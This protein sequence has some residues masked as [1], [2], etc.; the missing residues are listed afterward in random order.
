MNS[1][2]ISARH[3]LVDNEYEAKDILKLLK[4]GKSFSDLAQ[5]FSKCPSAKLGGDLGEFAQGRMVEAFNATAFTL[6]V[7]EISAPVR[8]RFGY[9]IIQRYK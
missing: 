9:H 4:E 8:T 2:K 5:K 7:D 6:T 1:A 3:I